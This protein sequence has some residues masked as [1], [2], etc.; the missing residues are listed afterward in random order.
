MEVNAKTFVEL[1][2]SGKMNQSEKFGTWFSSTDK[3]DGKQLIDDLKMRYDKAKKH[4]ELMEQYINVLKAEDI[5]D[6]INDKKIT[7]LFEGIKDTKREKNF[8]KPIKPLK[9]TTIKCV[10]Y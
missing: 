2:N 8:Y 6:I 9:L 5:D 7:K 4:L 1:V 3:Q 10:G